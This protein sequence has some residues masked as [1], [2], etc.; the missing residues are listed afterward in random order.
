MRVVLHGDS[1]DE[2]AAEA[3]RLVAEEG[4][5]LIHP[6]D[7]PY[8]IA[9]Q[10]TIGLEVVKQLTPKQMPGVCGWVGVGVC[11]FVCVSVCVCVCACVLGK[12]GCSSTPMVALTS[13][14]ARGLSGWRW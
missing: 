6:Y 8:V 7:D 13:L 3:M 5:V 1:Y 4:R 14:L 9:G 12:G 10:G 11:L 2:A